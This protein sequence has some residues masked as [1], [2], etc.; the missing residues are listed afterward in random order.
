MALAVLELALSTRLASNSQSS[1]SQVLGLKTYATIAWVKKQFLKNEA[2]YR[3]HDVMN[4]GI[5][6][7]IYYI[8][9]LVYK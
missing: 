2:T 4:T 6:A 8:V 1:V 5:S 7:Q 9:G 3:T